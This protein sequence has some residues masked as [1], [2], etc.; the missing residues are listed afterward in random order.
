M[1]PGRRPTAAHHVLS[2]GKSWR[3]AE[4]TVDKALGIIQS[5]AHPPS[6]QFFISFLSLYVSIP[7]SLSL[8]FIFQIISRSCCSRAV[9]ARRRSR[10]ASTSR[11]QQQTRKGIT[12]N[13]LLRRP[14]ELLFDLDVNCA[15]RRHRA[16]NMTTPSPSHL[17]PAALIAAQH[18]RYEKERSQCYWWRRMSD[19]KEEP[20]PPPSRLKPISGGERCRYLFASAR[21]TTR[22]RVCIVCFSRLRVSDNNADGVPQNA[23]RTTKL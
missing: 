1:L 8:C 9:N 6:T 15:A 12:F 17:F 13:R 19:E 16:P 3:A 4:S 14:S 23:P 11:G 18:V 21:S 10:A 20:T 5:S 22:A 7:P 2:C